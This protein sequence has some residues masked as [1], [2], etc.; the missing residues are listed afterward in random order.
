MERDRSEGWQWAKLSGHKNEDIAVGKVTNDKEFQQRILNAVG[1]PNAKI[2]SI[3]VGGLHETNVKSV[4]GGTTKNKTDMHITLDDGAKINISIKKSLGGQVF[5]ISPQRFIKGFEV[6]FDKVIPEK[7]KKAI[8]LYWGDDAD[9]IPII[10]KH[11]KDPKQ[12]NYE[13]RY[14]RITKDTMDKVD[15]T[16]SKVLLQW[17]DENM[18]D[19]IVFCFASGLVEDKDDWANL[20]WYVNFVDDN[21]DLDMMFSVEDI[22]KA[23]FQKCFYGSVYGGSTIQ[24]P[25]GFVQYH[26]PGHKGNPNLQFH[27]SFDKVNKLIKK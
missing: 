3:S 22:K 16:Y 19:I 2:T 23:S 24:L 14:N 20:I 17:F 11:T 1:H 15:E 4:L 12:A 8:R 9:I 7:V 18:G 25:F 27:H 13:L 26:D 5:L 21:E 10:K 6:Q